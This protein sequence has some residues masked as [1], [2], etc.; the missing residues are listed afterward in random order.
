MEAEGWDDM[1][2]DTSGRG[3]SFG[4]GPGLVAVEGLGEHEVSHGRVV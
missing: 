3:S 2:S 4:T 1:E